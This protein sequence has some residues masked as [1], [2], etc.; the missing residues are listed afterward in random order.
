M[1]ELVYIATIVLI[2]L[3]AIGFMAIKV[4]PVTVILMIVA[5]IA[6]L[7]RIVLEKPLLR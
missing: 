5:I 6:L 3:W 7:M 4:Y 2:I 1:N